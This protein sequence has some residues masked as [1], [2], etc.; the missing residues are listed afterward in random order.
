LIQCIA[1]KDFQ[2]FDLY[3]ENLKKIKTNNLD[4]EAEY[5][6][7]EKYVEHFYFLN[8]GEL[9]AAAAL[10]P[11]IEAGFLKYVHKI[12]KARERAF[13]FNMML[14]DLALTDYEAALLQISKIIN[15]KKSPH[16]EDIAI[17]AK[18]FEL[19]IQYELRDH[20]ALDVRVRSLIENL[21]Y[22]DNYLDFERTVLLGLGKL[23]KNQQGSFNDKQ[24]SLNAK[25]IL[26]KLSIDLLALK[27][28]D[29]FKKPI[30][31]DEINLWIR[32]KIEG[33]TFRELMFL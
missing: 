19:V 30:G 21:K 26:D 16:R 11:A 17:A 12:N 25:I 33:K 7:N 5:F 8:R 31:F 14:T 27:Q 4:D 20:H 32:A 23:I 24:E 18:L 1:T 22:N 13:R 6:Q 9:E 29:N 3:F 2:S 10:T 28:S 15:V